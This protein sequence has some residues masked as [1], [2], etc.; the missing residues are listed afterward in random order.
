MVVNMRAGKEKKE[1]EELAKIWEKILQ[2]D[3]INEQLEIAE[4]YFGE[5]KVEEDGDW[6][7]TYKGKKFWL[8]ADEK[9]HFNP[10]IDIREI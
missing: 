3:D 1:M 7:V 6:I 2:S 9:G 8:H 10:N 4:K 5:Y